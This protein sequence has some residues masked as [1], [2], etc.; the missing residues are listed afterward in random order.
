MII[1]INE[2]STLN[3]LGAWYIQNLWKY[4]HAKSYKEI[5]IIIGNKMLKKQQMK[6]ITITQ[7]S[8]VIANSKLET[9]KNENWS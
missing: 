9:Q 7:N 2:T 4:D 5:T 3:Q 6:N 8:Q 1:N